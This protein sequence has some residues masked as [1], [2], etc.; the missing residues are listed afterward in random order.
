MLEE[1]ARAGWTVIEKFDNGRVRLKRPASARASDA[2]LG[3]DPY[4]TWVG[5]SQTRLVLMIVLAALGLARAY[6]PDIARC[7]V[8]RL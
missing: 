4:R 2:T 8:I 6:S 1:E 5:I 7:W 3:F